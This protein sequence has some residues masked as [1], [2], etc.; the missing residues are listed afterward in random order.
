[1]Q[2]III[3]THTCAI[4]L[5]FQAS[6]GIPQHGCHLGFSTFDSGLW[7]W[8]LARAVEATS[9]DCLCMEYF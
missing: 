8:I 7:L 1:M 9:L 2:I 4:A 5:I 6:E 3:M